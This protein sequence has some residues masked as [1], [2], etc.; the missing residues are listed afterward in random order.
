MTREYLRL[1]T[2][3]VALSAL[4]LLVNV[5]LSWL[6]RLGLGAR[7]VVAAARMTAQLVLIGYVLDWI[8][9]LERPLEVVILAFV[10]A[11]LASVAAVGRTSRRFAGAYLDSL[12]SVLG[13]SFLVTGISL[14]GIIEVRPW[15][16]AH[17]LVP[18][19]GMVL[20]NALTGISLSVDRF[21]EGLEDRRDGIEARL[22]LGATSWEAALEEIRAAMRVGM[23]PTLNSMAVMG[24]VSLPGMMTGQILAG[25][26]PGEAVRYQI[27]IMFMIASATALGM[28]G[29]VLLAFRTLF[30]RW[31]RLRL[32]RI[33]MPTDW[34]AWTRRR[35]PGSRTFG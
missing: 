19:L 14:L 13:A 32:D 11:T 9:S 35:L 4:L 24:V 29:M 15:W 30:D 17:Y 8:F 21:V 26:A 27:V 28:L 3:Q 33:R 5:V 25:A 22:A 18:L 12:V 34:I 31:H 16:D 20:G 1:E 7:L 2:M 23:I 6:L 10:M